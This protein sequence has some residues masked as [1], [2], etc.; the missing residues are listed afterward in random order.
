MRFYS[1]KGLFTGIIVWGTV[2]FFDYF[3]SISTRRAR[4][5]GG[6]HFGSHNL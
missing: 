6:D 4:R 3:V 2:A 1:K 5:E